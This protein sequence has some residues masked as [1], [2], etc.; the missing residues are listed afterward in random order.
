MKRLLVLVPLV[1]LSLCSC[2]SKTWQ[3]ANHLQTASSHLSKSGFEEVVIDS[4]NK[5]LEIED[6]AEAYY[7]RGI[8]RDDLGQRLLAKQDL[9][10][11]IEIN[12][13]IAK[14]HYV[15]GNI[16]NS[17]NEEGLAIA[18]FTKAIKLFPKHI[19]AIGNR[20][21]ARRKSGDYQGALDDFTKAIAIKPNHANNI[22]MRGSV[23][24]EIG[25]YN[26]ALQDFNTAA[27]ID[28]KIAD[29]RSWSTGV[30]AGI[31]YD[32][33]YAFLKLGEPES[34]CSDFEKASSLGNT[35]AL[36]VFNDLCK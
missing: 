1:C 11:A 13:E 18:S 28:P 2:E 19:N 26:G 31:Y 23:K 33:A 27:A 9:L 7:M 4:A 20:A 12:N 6:N 25:D 24:Y 5:I 22:R 16:Y 15:L 8:A 14:Y 21:S 29:N 10:K 35:Y 3:K 30:H 32:R 17:M 34:A 36:E